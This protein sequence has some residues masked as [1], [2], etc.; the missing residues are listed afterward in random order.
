MHCTES[1]GIDTGS[2]PLS[3]FDRC[4]RSR[5]GANL[6][7]LAIAKRLVDKSTA[8]AEGNF[9]FSAQI[10]AC[11]FASVKFSSVK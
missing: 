10:V 6:R 7:M 8:T 1:P 3:R 9:L 5:L 4:F 11:P 2:L